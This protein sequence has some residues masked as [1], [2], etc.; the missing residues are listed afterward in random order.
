M[1]SKVVDNEPAVDLFTGLPCVHPFTPGSRKAVLAPHGVI[2]VCLGCGR[3]K[4]GGD[5]HYD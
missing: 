4:N 1:A 3:N 5:F 2:V